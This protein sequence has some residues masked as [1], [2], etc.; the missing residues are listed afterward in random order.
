MC[1]PEL[2]SSESLL[3][4]TLRVSVWCLALCVHVTHSDLVEFIAF[5]MVSHGIYE[6]DWSSSSTTDKNSVTFTEK[7][8]ELTKSMTTYQTAT[9]KLRAKQDWQCL[10]ISKMTPHDT[11]APQSPTQT[12]NHAYQPTSEVLRSPFPFVISRT[13]PA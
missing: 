7:G 13:H 6:V 2:Y 4:L 11:G 10:F 12:T 1:G 3:T 8:D 5:S 9:S